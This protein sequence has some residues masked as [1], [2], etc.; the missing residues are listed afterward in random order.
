D[1]RQA[2]AE[3]RRRLLAARAVAGHEQD[4]AAPG[5]AQRGVDRGLADLGAVEPQALIVAAGDRVVHVA[6][7]LA[8]AGVHPDEQRGVAALLEERRVARP[9]LLYDPLAVGMQVLCDQ[10]VERPVAAGAMAVH[11]E[12]LVGARW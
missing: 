1:G 12:D 3:Q 6:E 11:E 5:A 10:R 8:G 9:L 2:A 7:L 4:G